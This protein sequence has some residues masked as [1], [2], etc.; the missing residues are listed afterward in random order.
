MHAAARLTCSRFTTAQVPPV[1]LADA[2]RILG[3]AV[4]AC[5]VFAA[6]ICALYLVKSALGINIFSGHSPLLHAAL[7]PLV[8]G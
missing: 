7:Y 5:T 4:V 1:S 8:H 3:L 6:G 2:A